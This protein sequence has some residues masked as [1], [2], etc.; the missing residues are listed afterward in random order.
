[1]ESREAYKCCRSKDFIGERIH[2]LTEVSNKIV[3]SRNKTIQP[4]SEGRHDEN[5]KC[6]SEAE[7]KIDRETEDKHAMRAK[8]WQA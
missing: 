3:P 5:E 7:R 6:R 1:M 8:A 2:E 4:I